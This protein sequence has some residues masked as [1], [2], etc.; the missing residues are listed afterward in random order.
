M[1]HKKFQN[2]QGKINK[3]IYNFILKK[4][5]GISRKDALKILMGYTEHHNNEQGVSI[6][7]I[8]KLAKKYGLKLLKEE[9]Q[10]HEPY[11]NK[12]WFAIFEKK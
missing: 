9:L 3:I 12:L 5:P 1:N 8:K 2:Y 10:R 11:Q 6:F 7:R 4:L